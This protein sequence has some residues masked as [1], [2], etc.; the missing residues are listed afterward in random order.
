MPKRRIL[1]VEDDNLL[2]TQYRSALAYA[3]FDVDIAAD[4]LSA[5]ETIDQA[6]PD[7]VVT[8]LRMP[9]IGAEAILSEA[10]A[11]PHTSHIPFIVLTGAES[12]LPGL[13]ASAVMQKPCAPSD[14]VAMVERH[15]Q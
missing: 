5:L 2:A 1:V 12:M 7:L 3:G 14:L 15:L 4:G 6:H 13:R 9:E 8:E 11:T 10:A